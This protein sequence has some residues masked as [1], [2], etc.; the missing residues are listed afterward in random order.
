LECVRHGI[1]QRGVFGRGA[2][3]QLA[4]V[5]DDNSE[6]GAELAAIASARSWLWI[7]CPTN[8]T[9]RLSGKWRKKVV[10]VS[11]SRSAEW[12]ILGEL[13]MR[14]FVTGASGHVA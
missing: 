11:P 8:N 5:G 10:L 4:V 2:F 14:V 9:S 1:G 12:L 7:S 13:L 6:P 3:L